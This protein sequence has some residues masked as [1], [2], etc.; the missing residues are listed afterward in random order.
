MA[1]RTDWKTANIGRGLLLGGLLIAA[2]SCTKG[3]TD[4]SIQ[5]FADE[6]PEITVS[7]INPTSAHGVQGIDVVTT[8][9]GDGVT[10]SLVA[11]NGFE[12]GEQLFFNVG[13]NPSTAHAEA[14]QSVVSAQGENVVSLAIESQPGSIDFGA[15]STAQGG[16]A[17]SPGDTLMSFKLKP[18]E[19]DLGKYVSSAG[20]NPSLSRAKNLEFHK[21][22][23][24]NWVLEW[25]Y[26]NPGDYNQDGEVS[27]TDIT[28]I[29]VHFGQRV[30]NSWNDKK[31][32]IDADSNGEINL[33][34]ITPMGQNYGA[35]IFAYNI[36]MSENGD[37]GFIVVG[38]LL[39]DEEEELEPGETKRFAYEFGAQYVVGGWYR[40][41][42]LDKELQFGSPSEAISEF[43]RRMAP[44]PYA[45]GQKALVTVFGQNMPGNIAH[46]NAIRVV[47]PAS[48][49]YVPGSANAG[50]PGGN[51]WDPDGIWKGFADS[52]L[53]PPDAFHKV[54]EL[55]NGKRAMDFNVTSLNRRSPASPDLYGDIVNFK[56]ESTSGEPLTLEFMVYDDAGIHRTYFS[57]GDENAVDFGNALGLRLN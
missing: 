13:F 22:D 10:V 21:N 55:G 36:E 44:V 6:M 40:V 8:P 2:A 50:K 39:V 24:G 48:Y 20:R 29:G 18:G 47:F 19:A 41:V 30:A 56:L 42:P 51:P 43:G 17:A 28:P 31:R 45:A 12:A 5:G 35:R 7:A 33:G 46:A 3:N 1:H 37:D 26:T 11:A 32:H 34:D 57:D 15:V 9:E 4:G 52:L 49:D 53:F 23:G 25:D 54:E 27:I 14:V 16:S 38:Q